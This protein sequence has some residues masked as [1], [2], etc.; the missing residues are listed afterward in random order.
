[1]ERVLNQDDHGSESSLVEED[2]HLCRF[3]QREDMDEESAP[4]MNERCSCYKLEGDAAAAVVAFDC[5]N[6]RFP[7]C[8]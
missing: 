2:A 4:R 5:L 7:T 1:M 3:D 6:P 8:L